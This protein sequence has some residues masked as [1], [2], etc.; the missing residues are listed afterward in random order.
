MKTITIGLFGAGR[1]GRLHGENLIH[2]FRNVR[3]KYLV[4]AYL[5]DDMKEWATSVGIEQVSTDP[6]VI[7]QDPEVDAILICSSTN[8]HADLIESGAKAKKDIFCEKPLDLNIT[9]I[10][11][12]LKVV[13]EHKVRL[14]VGFVRRFDHNYCGLHQAVSQGKIG[15]PNIVRITSR[16]PDFPSMDYLRYS[17]GIFVDQAVHDLDMARYLIGAE[18]VEI[19]SYGSCLLRPEIQDFEDVDTAVTVIRFE[20]GALATIDNSRKAVYGYDQ[21]AEVFGTEGCVCMSNDTP[22]N[23]VTLTGEGV[24]S[25]KPH[26]FFLER[27]NQGFINEMTDFFQMLQSDAMPSVT[28]HDGLMAVYMAE[29]ATMSSRQGRPVK[30]QEI[31]DLYN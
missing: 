12:I 29:A 31:I 26:W 28:G 3:I 6:Q 17:G 8:T 20:N 14:Q 21:R 16:D 5:N 23:A 19:F 11:E 18:P 27:Y 13:E 9:R 24:C 7:F 25:E 4:D 30:I 22:H 1:I 10:K 2:S 15:S